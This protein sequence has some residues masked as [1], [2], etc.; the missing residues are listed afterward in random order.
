LQGGGF[1]FLG[2]GRLPLPS[3]DFDVSA[4][5]LLFRASRRNSIVL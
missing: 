5:G 4:Q 1:Q 3:Q 2:R